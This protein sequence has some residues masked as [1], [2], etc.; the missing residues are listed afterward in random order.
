MPWLHLD[1]ERWSNAVLTDD[2]GEP[3]AQISNV[4]VDSDGFGTRRFQI[5]FVVLDNAAF[6]EAMRC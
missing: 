2:N 3:I 1:I 4:T 5:E 6:N